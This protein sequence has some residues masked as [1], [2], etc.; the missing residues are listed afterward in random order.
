MGLGGEMRNINCLPVCYWIGYAVIFK[1]KRAGG[2]IPLS[3][4]C[5]F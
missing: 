1:D 5:L 2:L 3:Y 4:L